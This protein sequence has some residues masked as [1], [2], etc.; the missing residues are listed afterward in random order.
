M[1]SRVHFRAYWL[2][3]IMLNMHN[4]NKLKPLTTYS[5][6]VVILQVNSN[7][8]KLSTIN[9]TK[10]LFVSRSSSMSLLF[11][12]VSATTS[13]T[14][15][16]YKLEPCTTTATTLNNHLTQY[17]LSINQFNS[18]MMC[19]LDYIRKCV[20]LSSVN[21]IIQFL[22]STKFKINKINMIWNTRQI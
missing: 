15:T 10:L 22:R 14:F 17:Y 13:Q 3:S 1:F 21:F 20:C 8:S 7:C 12:L 4:Y 2:T 5:V 19:L 18:W 11:R 6:S 9:V 16:V